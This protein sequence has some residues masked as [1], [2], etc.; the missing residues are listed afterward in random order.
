MKHLYRLLFLPLGL[1]PFSLAAQ[2]APDCANCACGF[3]N[4]ANI[5]QNLYT[6]TPAGHNGA[7]PNYGDAQT[8]SN[9]G[10]FNRRFHRVY[11]LSGDQYT[12]SLCGGSYDT[13]L[14]ITNNAATP[15]EYAC[16]DDG[17]GVANGPSIVSFTAPINGIYRIYA[18]DGTCGTPFIDP[19]PFLSL[20]IT[21]NAPATPP[22][23]DEPCGAIALPMNSDCQFFNTGSNA[24]TLS[25][26]AGAGT[27]PAGCVSGALLQN[28]VWFSTTVPPSGLI[29]IATE[30]GSICAGSYNLYTATACNGT[31]T[32]LPS[33]CVMNGP[34]GPTTEPAGV[35]DAFAAGLT[36]GQTVYIR[37][38]ER[39]GNEN[40][41]FGICAYEAQ[42][43]VND[44]PC[45]ALELP[46]NVGCTFNTFATTNATPLAPNI[47]IAGPPLCAGAGP[48]TNDLWFRVTVTP[49]MVANGFFV[50]TQ[51]GSL[52]DMAM[53]W[54]RL[55]A[56]T[57]CG[58]GTMTQV[59][60]NNNQTGSNLF[61]RINSITAGL[62]LVAGETIYV[63]VWPQTPWEGTFNICASVNQPPPNNTPCTAQALPVNFG[64]SLQNFTTENA[65]ATGHPFPNG[66]FSSGT[67]TPTCF[68]QFHEDVWFTV[69]MP[70]NGVI[71][72][73]TYAG[74]MTTAGMTLYSATGSCA[75]GN[76]TLTQL[77]C[78]QTGSQQGPTSVN[79]PYINYTNLALA[80]QTLYVRVMRRGNSNPTGTFGIC[81]RRT[82][83]PP[84][85]C[86]YTLTLNDSAGDGW[87]GSFVTVCVG[88]VCNNY[89]LFGASSSINIGTNIGQV[90]TVSYTQVGGFNNQNSFTLT[91]FGGQLYASGANPFTGVHYV[92]SVDCNPPPAP[93]SDCFGAFQL[94]NQNIQNAQAP[95]NTG[96]TNDLPTAAIRGCLQGER[97]GLWYSWQVQDPGA[98]TF[99][100]Y[101][102]PWPVLPGTPTTIFDWAVWGPFPGGS[103]CTLTSGPGQAPLRCNFATAWLT[104][105]GMAYNFS[106]PFYNNGPATPVN[107]QHIQANAGEWYLL[108]VDNWSMTGLNF[109][110]V[111]GP[112]PGTPTPPQS[113][114][115][116]CVQLPSNNM[117]V[118]AKARARHV[119]V[120]WTTLSEQD[121]AFYEVL[122]SANGVDFI[123]IGRVSATGT[124][125]NMSQY[126][127]VD[128]QPLDGTG[129]YRVRQVDTYG[130]HKLSE[131]REVFFR[132]F[133]G[134]LDVFPN[135]ATDALWAD[136]VRIEDGRVD[137][138]VLDASGRQ[139]MQG[140]E[141]GLR[142][143]DRMELRIGRLDAGSYTLD[144]RDERGEPMG[145]ARFIKQ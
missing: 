77:A 116:D 18:Y 53:A 41:S 127:F 34:T 89:T 5:P 64:C 38:W 43:P 66:G 122:R 31:F 87:S 99:T 19:V 141:S 133:A 4:L 39:N 24:A 12:F 74:T 70:P 51:G 71:Q 140:S 78:A 14:W 9:A 21:R 111:W 11:L 131:V 109:S 82:D 59:A 40:G 144:V 23:N 92:A 44:N 58:P 105:K 126:R 3:G 47:T 10:L 49:A 137:W 98:I 27:A 54:Y 80:G 117:L 120:D 104:P 2:Q 33:S 17:C 46:V 118:D 112:P 32:Q 136:I 128:D 28:D 22:P 142:G 83:N 94:C 35:Y 130:Q 63:R 6:I 25:V 124:T 101:P 102:D 135:P 86:F 26:I 107:V 1:L 113:A 114:T 68:A 8:Y 139:V 106:L 90:V 123:P 62:T 52:A 119:D 55:T 61:P 73:D 65:T 143:P 79:M 67:A 95:A 76:L 13:Y 145:Q 69:V 7:F 45:G 115:I 108:Y 37:Y 72:L 60:C 91:Q 30:E 84:T 132:P 81:A 96:N 48:A 57:A 138:R 15:V 36:V 42:R 56:G 134:R 20:T 85:N 121:V 100:I 103:P 50:N 93:Q 129:Y 29:G 97:Q 16:D 88:G 125:A 110:I 75:S